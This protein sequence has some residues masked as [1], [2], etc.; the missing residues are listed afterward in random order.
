MTKR[1]LILLGLAVLCVA[2]P[3]ASFADHG[4]G[5]DRGD[6]DRRESDRRDG[7]RRERSD[8]RHAPDVTL[9]EISERVTFDPDPQNPGIILRTA[10]SPLLGFAVVGTPLCPPDLQIV[11]PRLNRCAVIA[12]GTSRVSVVTGLGRVSGTFDVVINA[13]GNDPVHIP[14][15]PVLSGTFEGSVNLSSA[16]VHRVP[17]G[18]VTGNFAI[19]HV[20]DP[21]TG[22]LVALPTP[23]TLP[24][25][26]TFRLPFG[27]DLV[28]RT[29]RHRDSLAHFYLEDDVRTH[30]RI[31][32]DERSIGFPTV[33][34]E[35]NFP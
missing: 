28:G 11:V 3:A 9:Y 13:P 5:D 21:N 16:V 29:V 30:I 20:A 15:L 32:S 4:E 34:L 25:T 12:D 27:L 10:T 22:Q 14:D 2:L 18:S 19:T 17:L 26:G 8:R 33:R 35:L 31:K 23:L 24:F 1:A 6:G 7:D